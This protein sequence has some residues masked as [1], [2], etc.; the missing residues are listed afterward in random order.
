MKW[1]GAYP[2]GIVAPGALLASAIIAF[3]SVM[4]FLVVPLATEPLADMRI[5]PSSGTLTVGSTFDVKVLVSAKTP[6]NVFKGALT[7][8]HTKLSVDSISYNTSIANIWAEEPWYRNGEGTLGFIG[9]TSR[10][11]GFLGDGELL[12]ITF[13]SMKEGDA[14]IRFHEARILEHDGLG[15]DATLESPIDSI[16]LVEQAELERETVAVPLP[17]EARIASVKEYARTD[18]NYDGKQSLADISIF[19]LNMMGDN[20][21]FDFNTDGK[22]TTKD[23]SIILSAER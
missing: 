23:L 12:V 10:S 18:L 2:D 7:F 13:R 20:P 6:V 15:T 8:D 3:L 4:G 9:G 1:K 16:F 21:R 14:V 19:M 17:D 11:G 5:E 22:V